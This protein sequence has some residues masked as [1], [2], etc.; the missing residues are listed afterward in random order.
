VRGFRIELGEIE[1][2]VRQHS[3]VQESV[4][5]VREESVDSQRIVAYIVP[6]KEQTLTITELRD[7]LESKLPNYMV[8]AA[9]VM[10]E[11]LPLTPNGKVDRKALPA[12]EVTQLLSESNF[13]APSTPIEEMLAL[14]WAEVLSIEKVGIHN[15][16]FSLGGHSLLATR[17]ISQVRQVFQQ[18]LPLRRLF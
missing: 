18:E 3:K 2:L 14:I 9:F 15:N 10:L 5:V 1:A 11:S 6:Q 4:V 7:F 12:P 17:V 13:V 16:F 8:P